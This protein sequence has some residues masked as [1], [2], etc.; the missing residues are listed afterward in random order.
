M[1][2]IDIWEFDNRISIKVKE[3]FLAKIKNRLFSRYKTKRKMY[4]L[5]QNEI[6]FSFYGFKN[7]LKEGYQK[8]FFVPLKIWMCMCK[9][10]DIDLHD[11]QENITAYKTSGG[12]NFVSNPVLPV[13]ISP[14]FDMIIAHNIADGTVINPKKGRL[15]YFGY[16]QFDALFREL[17]IRKLNAIFGKINFPEEY[18]ILSTRP[19]C[20]PFL[21]TLFFKRYKLNTSSFLSK[22]ARIPAEILNKNSEYLLAVLIAFVIDEAS[23]DSTLIAIKLKNIELTND[24]FK[25]CKKLG[26]RTT[27]TIKEEYGTLS[28]L[29]K[30]MKKFFNDYK[31][32]IKKYP[33]MTLG[34]WETKIENTFKIYDRPIYKTKGN[35][36]LIIKMLKIENLTINQ[37]ALRIN[38]TRQGVRFHINNLEKQGLISRVGY[39]GKKNIIYSYTG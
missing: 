33:E 27:V 25:I 38:M 17:Y 18:Y 20:P 35:K 1:E 13:K 37:L 9:L 16:R 3:I 19:Y 15:P 6:K 26:Y 21:A 32:I 23:I 34:K 14:L 22:E 10:V 8:K 30:G 4:E 31:R 12:P 28:I 11:L 24:L 7:L 29:R 5:I 39:V 2:E 36:N